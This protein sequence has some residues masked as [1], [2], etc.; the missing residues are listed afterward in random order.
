MVEGSVDV[1][2]VDRAP[3]FGYEAL[4][5]G[6]GAVVGGG[7]GEGGQQQEEGEAES[8]NEGSFRF[9]DGFGVVVVAMVPVL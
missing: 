8:Q 2:V 6:E 3:D 5:V 4:F 7:G 9:D 1:G